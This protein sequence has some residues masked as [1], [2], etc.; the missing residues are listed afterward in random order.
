MPALDGGALTNVN[1]VKIQG[2]TLSSTTPS[3]GHVLK[4]NASA[5]SWGAAP[6]AAPIGIL[7]ESGA[8]LEEPLERQTGAKGCEL[9]SP[10][11][12]RAE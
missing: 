6:D 7:N 5:S 9:P 12:R 2:R 4:W 10:A 3:D 1:S 8:P 11:A